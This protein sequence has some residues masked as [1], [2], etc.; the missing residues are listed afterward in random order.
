MLSTPQARPTG[1]LLALEVGLCRGHTAGAG[2]ALRLQGHSQQHRAA[3]QGAGQ[4]G[5]GAGQPRQGHRL[6]AKLWPQT[7]TDEVRM[8]S[9]A[10]LAVQPWSH[11][12]LTPAVAGHLQGCSRR[13]PGHTHLGSSSMLT[14]AARAGRAITCPT[15]AR[16]AGWSLQQAPAVPGWDTAQ[17]VPLRRRK[18]QRAWPRCCSL[19]QAATCW[20]HQQ[21]LCSKDGR[22]AAATWW[23][24]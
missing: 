18:R 15:P 2:G 1:T 20:A 19:L 8:P 3:R 11:T 16:P 13:P 23:S 5:Q 9:V 10:S 22:L 21:G 6:S 7:V 24:E 12:T 4:P 17:P 14:A